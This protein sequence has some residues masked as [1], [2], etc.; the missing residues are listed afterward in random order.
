MYTNSFGERQANDES[1]ATFPLQCPAPLWTEARSYGVKKNRM[2]YEKIN[3]WR[4][5]TQSTAP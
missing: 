2:I 5:E 1:Q 4:G 3:F